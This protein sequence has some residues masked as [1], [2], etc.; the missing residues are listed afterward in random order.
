MGTFKRQRPT[1]LVIMGPITILLADREKGPKR[2][3][4]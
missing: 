1:V 3:D 4:L 2:N